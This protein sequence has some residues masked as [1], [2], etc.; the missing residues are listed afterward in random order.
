MPTTVD[1]DGVTVD[2]RRMSNSQP[3]RGPAG[4]GQREGLR[5]LEIAL[6]S[7]GQGIVLVDAQGKLVFANEAARR[8][9]QQKLFQQLTCDAAAKPPQGD[10]AKP[11]PGGADMPL[12]GGAEVLTL[13]GRPLPPQQAPLCR[14]LRGEVV[15][16]HQVLASRG[17]G[18]ETYVNLMASPVRD[19]QGKIIG[20]LAIYQDI[21]LD[22]QAEEDRRRLAAIVESS[23]DAILGK[24]LD[25]IIT[26]WNRGAEKLY[27]YTAPEV[28][29]KS[30]AILIPPERQQELKTILDRIRRGERVEHYETQRVRKDGTRVDVSVTISPI[31]NGEGRLVGASAIAR[32]ITALKQS[33]RERERLLQEVE[34]LA[35]DARRRAT[36][37]QSVLENMV[38]GVLVCDAKARVVMANPSARRMLGFQSEEEIR[39]PLPELLERLPMQSPQGTPLTPEQMPLARALKGETVQAFDEVFRHPRTGQLTY[40]RVS[41][42]PIRDEKGAI[43]GAVTVFR[44]ITELAELDRLRDQFVSVAAHELK[45]PVTIMK[46][47]A[48]MLLRAAGEMAPRH[49]R[50]VEAIDRGSDRINRI[51]KDLLDISRLH[52]GRLEL[53]HER[54]DLP[55][56][57]S[58]VTEQASLVGGRTIRITR[59]DPATVEGD[60]DRL[61]QALANLLDNAIKYSPQGGDVDVAVEARAGE[62]VVSVTDRGVGIP[63]EK[64]RRIFEPFYRA[65][66][67][68]PHDYGGMGVGLYITREIISRHGG[69]I[70]FE[71][72][73]GR[74]STFHIALPTAQG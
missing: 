10:A 9:L 33:E 57:V 11:A 69:R 55:V 8:L 4:R 48:Q 50:M 64:Q 73:E 40:L 6:A 59:A 63:R 62:A 16:A 21:S 41:A 29:G 36:E 66:T 3:W 56:L 46:G 5:F 61:G 54:I 34:R 71:S 18:V 52:L 60:P 53:E 2:S 35:R 7:A 25:G 58:Q 32:D 49:R 28:K 45:T 38:D 43:V 30:V 72:E 51:I 13:E 70:W 68:T 15:S 24:T 37:L 42:S 20:A 23:D 74:G 22:R 39:L 67:G 65:H 19:R 26:A 31:R 17:D 1:G 14:A 44:D 12:P 47:Y 27:G